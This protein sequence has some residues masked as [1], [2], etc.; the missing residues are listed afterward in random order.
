MRKRVRFGGE[1]HEVDAKGRIVRS[2][3]TA[4][5]MRANPAP[6]APASAAAA[7]Y[8]RFTGMQ[9]ERAL[10]VNYPENPVAGLAI[11]PCLEVAYETVRDGVVERY[12]HKFAPNARPTLVASHDGRQLYLLG[13]AYRFTDRGIVDARPKRKG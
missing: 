10:R 2:L 8:R 6:R 13:G 7:R 11:G 9:P 1:V 12:R 4:P 5:A 3:P